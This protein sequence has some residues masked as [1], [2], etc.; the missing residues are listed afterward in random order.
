MRWY[1]DNS[2]LHGIRDTDIPDILLFGGIAVP[3]RVERALQRALEDVKGQ[4]G[5]ARSPV[6]WNFKNLRPEYKKRDQEALFEK[7]LKTS[8]QW[9]TALFE[10]A[11]KHDFQIVVSCLESHSVF[12]EKIKDVKAALSGYSFSNGLMRFGLCVQ[13]A[14]PEQAQVIV[15]WPDKHDCEP[16]TV[17]YQHAYS[18]GA[19]ST[20][21][22]YFC[23]PLRSIG[24]LDSV[25]YTTM[26]DSTLL[27]FADLIVGAT[28]E[29]VQC[30][31]GGREEGL[32]VTLTRSLKTKF[33]GAPNSIFGRG[34]NVASS[35]QR[36]RNQLKL[37]FDTK[38]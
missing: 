32:G 4:F 16:F 1:A 18:H 36:L 19:S 5:E 14:K 24:F 7:L 12:K 10:E 17:E 30:A 37:Y 29:V 13:I 33:Y 20:G 25:A 15:D 27:Q 8:A 11:A 38:L 22:K 21:Q 9:R 28:R 34:F 6:K 31:L 23:G 35:N 2:E 26:I 3:A